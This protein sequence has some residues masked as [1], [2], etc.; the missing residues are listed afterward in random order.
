MS[1]AVRPTYK[2]RG[3]HASDNGESQD[4]ENMSFDPDEAQE[5]MKTIKHFTQKS[6]SS[7]I[8]TAIDMRELLRN[9]SI[10]PD[11]NP[12]S[13]DSVENM[14]M[15]NQDNAA[16]RDNVPSSTLDSNIY[17]FSSDSASKF[18]SSTQ[19]EKMNNELKRELD[20]IREKFKSKR[21]ENQ[22]ID[23]T[24]PNELKEKITKNNRQ[25]SHAYPARASMIRGFTFK[26]GG[27]AG[28][29]IRKT[30]LGMVDAF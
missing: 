22:I 29:S 27:S 21:N 10:N 2:N 26:N 24:E 15:I 14:L 25:M 16:N 30:P 1:F 3:L 23:L 12:L 18:S 20:I 7:N 4:N 11:T 13:K 5:I 28:A 19:S 8:I 9:S 17:G 6:S